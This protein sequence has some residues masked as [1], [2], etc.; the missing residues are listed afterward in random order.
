MELK[1][2]PEQVNIVLAGLQELPHKFSDP[3][4]REIMQQVQSQNGD[5]DKEEE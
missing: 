5:T 4:I 2:T 3:V 1:L